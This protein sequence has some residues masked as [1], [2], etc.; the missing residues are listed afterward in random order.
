MSSTIAAIATAQAAAGIGV[1][2]I[3]GPDAR[4][5]ASTVFKKMRGTGIMESAG[6]TGAYGKIIE[7]GQVLDEAVAFVFAAPHSYTGEDIVEFSCHGGMFILQKV[8]RAVY[9][10]G[11]VPAEAGEFT[12][13]AFLNGKID[14]TQAEGIQNIIGAN[15]EQAARAA[16]AVREGA[17]SRQIAEIKEKLLF[18]AAHMSVWADYPDEDIETLETK[19]LKQQLKTANVI[20]Q[21]KI[22]QFDAGK[23]LREGVQT[24]IV[25]RPNVGK[26]TLM[27]LL[28]GTERSIVTPIAGTTRD[29]VE[30]T[31]RLGDI[32]LH[33]SDTAGLRRTDDMIESIGV[34]RA[35]EKIKEAALILAVFDCS[36][37]LEEQDFELLHM[38]KGRDAVAV[39]NKTDLEEWKID[40]EQLQLLISHVVL[41]S[42]STG[43]GYQ[44]LE[45]KVSEIIGTSKLDP[46]AGILASERQRN[47][48]VRA[49]DALQEAIIALE[50]GM[51]LDAVNVCTDEALAALMELTGEK[52][53]EAVSNEVFSKF[54]VGK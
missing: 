37:P 26:S 1:I 18:C 4:K 32:V 48:C 20:L 23:A 21:K 52:V 49:T 42:A 47:C 43:E 12:K 51:T 25:G 33:I 3:S 45:E 17:M 53:T 30:E 36:Q 38:L 7:N 5:I 19:K 13:R 39:V 44:K 22:S 6:Y 15:G 16:I 50:S 28:S 35:K 54:C 24:V 34:D 46:S 11:A 8:L 29:I 41:V 31:V 40:I 9:K 14:L 27:N 2:R 10:A